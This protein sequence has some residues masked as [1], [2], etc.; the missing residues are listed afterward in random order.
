MRMFHCHTNSS[1]QCFTWFAT[2]EEEEKAYTVDMAK[3]IKLHTCD[4]ILFLK[5]CVKFSLH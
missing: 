4:L 3:I 1:L 5:I 2:A